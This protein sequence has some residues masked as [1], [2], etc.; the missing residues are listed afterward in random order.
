M[1]T[2]HI[3][4]KYGNDPNASNIAQRGEEGKKLW[5][6]YMVDYH[7]YWTSFKNKYSALDQKSPYYRI[8]NASIFWA[9][10]RL[11]NF[12]LEEFWKG[13]FRFGSLYVLCNI[14]GKICVI[15]SELAT[16]THAAVYWPFFWMWEFFIPCL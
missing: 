6:S 3:L 9:K 5:T 11:K 4:Q 8:S 10:L 7:W 14:K 1:S 15:F 13:M 12:N 2:E 16:L